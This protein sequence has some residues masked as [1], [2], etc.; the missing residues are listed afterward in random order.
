MM[1]IR[2]EATT[3]YEKAEAVARDAFWNLYKPGAE[4][5][6]LLKQMRT[7]RDYIPEL[8]FVAEVD[9]EVV[10]AVYATRSKIVQ[11]DGA[12]ISTVT[13]GPVFVAPNLHRQGIGRAMITHAIAEAKEM[14]FAAVTLLGYPYHYKP[15]GFAGGKKY[16]VTAEDGKFYAGLQILPLAE[17]AMAGVSGYAVFSEVFEVDLAD[18]DRVEAAL[19]YKEKRVLPSQQEYEIAC[20]ELEE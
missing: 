12:E 1:I 7:H 4:E 5:H 16:N 11:T 19:P 14:G 15:Y 17:A 9:G 3:D 8:T 18:V 13:F 20:Q 2:N 6:V 10:G